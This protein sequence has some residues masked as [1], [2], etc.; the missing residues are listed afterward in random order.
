[1]QND[2]QLK[3]TL[4]HDLE[5]LHQAQAE[6]LFD[7]QVDH[8]DVRVH[9]DRI[10]DALK[11]ARAE[12]NRLGDHSEEAAREIEAASRRHLNDAKAHVAKLRSAVAARSG[13][14]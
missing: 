8:L 10:E 13:R 12:I 2:G 14:G 7:V 5:E 6:L 11:F 4:L 1:M 3:Q 9:W